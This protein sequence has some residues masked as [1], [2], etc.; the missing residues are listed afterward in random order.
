MKLIGRPL[1]LSQL[2]EIMNTP[3]IKVIEGIS[4]INIPR[5]LLE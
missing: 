1:Y 4:I 3:D 5:W 2:K